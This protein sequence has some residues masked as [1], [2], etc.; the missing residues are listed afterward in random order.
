MEAT[1][2]ILLPVSAAT[3]GEVLTASICKAAQEATQ[4]DYVLPLCETGKLL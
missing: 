4:M 1:F 2:T 3:S